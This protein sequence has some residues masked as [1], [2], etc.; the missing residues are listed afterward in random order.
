MVDYG[1]LCDAVAEV[2]MVVRGAFTHDHGQRED[3]RS[4]DVRDDQGDDDQGGS[5]RHVLMIGNVG[6]SMWPHFCA[7]ETTGAD[8]LDTWTR[9]VLGPLAERFG[10]TFVHPNDEPFQPFQQWAA[11]ADTVFPSPI[12][13]LIHPEFGLWH[14]YRGAFVFDEPIPGAPS[15]AGGSTSPFSTS[16][17]STSLGITSPCID[18]ADQPC[19][20]SCPVDA[21]SA[22]GYDVD[23]CAGH[24]RRGD[25][26][27]CREIGC[28]ARAACPVGVA[29][30]YGAAQM[31]FH[32][33]AFAVAR[34]V[35]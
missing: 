6:G 3:S 11:K 31:R 30:T 27:H 4:D 32:M 2:G 19:L 23:A 10:A 26:P 14:A 22:S 33:E 28:R 13:L 16:L 7:A 25:D 9:S 17:G 20:T 18:C 8:P 21:F 35:T 5:L 15:S 12:G 24:L 34:G 29:F 1:E